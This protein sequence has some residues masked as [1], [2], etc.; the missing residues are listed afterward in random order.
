MMIFIQKVLRNHTMIR[1]LLKETKERYFLNV[2]GKC[3]GK[4]FG[5]ESVPLFGLRE[6]SERRL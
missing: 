5:S 4:Y 6:D 3:G 2:S 1:L